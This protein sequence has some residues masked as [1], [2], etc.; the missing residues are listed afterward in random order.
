MPVTC[1]GDAHSPPVVSGPALAPKL[2]VPAEPALTASSVEPAT[3]TVPPLLM[4]SVP[5]LLPFGPNKRSPL[6]VH[7]EPAPLTVTVPECRSI[8]RCCNPR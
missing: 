2:I 6:L 5:L 4:F 7:V 3:E 1:A 8:C